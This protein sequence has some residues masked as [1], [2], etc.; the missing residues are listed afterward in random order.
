M[1]APAFGELVAEGVLASLDGVDAGAS[2]SPWIEAFD[3]GRF[4][5]DETFEIVEGMSVDGRVGE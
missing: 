2:D 3:P 1:R 5:G 4:D